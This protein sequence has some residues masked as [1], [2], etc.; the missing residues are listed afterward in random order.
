MRILSRLILLALCVVVSSASSQQTAQSDNSDWEPIFRQTGL[1]QPIVAENGMVASQHYLGSQVGRAML[2]RGGNAVDAA[3]AV[4]FALAVV[5]PRAGNL[6]GGGFMMVYLAES[7]RVIAIDYRET[8]PAKAHRDLFLDSD[9][10]PDSMLSRFHP[11]AAGVPGTVAGLE[12]AHSRY[13]QLSW[14][15]VLEPAIRLAENGFPV[16]RD[17]ERNLRRARHLQRDPESQK[18]FF[19]NGVAIKTDSLLVQHDLAKTLKAISKRGSRGFYRGSFA[20][21]LHKYMK[22]NGGIMTK[23]DLADYKPIVREPIQG[24]YRQKYEISAMPPPSS[25]GVHLVQ[26][27]SILNEHD[28][29]GKGWGSADHIHLVT[30]AMRFA[31]AERAVHLGD[32]DHYPVPMQWLTD[33]DRMAQFSESIDPWRALPADAFG[34]A[35]PPRHESTETT[36][37]S[38]VDKDGNAVANTYTL[39]FSYGSGLMVPGTGVI[40]NNELDDFSSAT[41]VPNAYGLVG[42]EANAVAATKRPLSSMTPTFVFKNGKLWLVTGSPGGPRIITA[43]L[44]QIINAIDFQQN[45]ATAALSPRFHHQWQPDKLFMEEGFSPDSTR[46]LHQRGHKIA[47]ATTLGSVTSIQI[48]D[49]FLFGVA[50]SRRPDSRVA[51]Y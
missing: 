25:G 46:L 45:V 42:S 19:P 5:L 6:G 23:D 48:E 15:E 41:N 28:L 26:M 34:K 21:A 27:L 7:D 10:Q 8:G 37:F 17:L 13:G 20:N 38:I 36:H 39:N 18:I 35:Q 47:P 16:S 3:V 40:L 4:G 22:D 50:D 30:E 32:P 44:H 9:G 31:F 24:R 11:L 14:E 43:V 49:G 33:K 51:G 29:R 2:A 1:H 12:L